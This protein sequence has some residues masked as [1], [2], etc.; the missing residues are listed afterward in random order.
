[1]AA[2]VSADPADHDPLFA[3]D[4]IFGGL[5]DDFLHG[6]SGDDAIGGHE[7]LP[8]SYIQ[9]FVEGEVA[10]LVRTD[11]TRPWNPGNILMFM[12]GDPHWNEPTPVRARTGEFYLYDE[13]D[14]RRVI[15]FKDDGEVWKGDDSPDAYK[16]YFLNA[17]DNEGALFNG[18]TEFEPNGDPIET[19]FVETESDGNDRIFGDMGND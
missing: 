15:L 10:G 4:V 8:E 1:M 14:P 9:L 17:R 11:F 3:D 13:Y 2:V 5:D 19:S 16:H 7:S 6:G 12:D 18:A